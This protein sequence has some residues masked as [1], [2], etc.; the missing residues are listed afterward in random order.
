MISTSF[1]EAADFCRRK[2]EQGKETKQ[3]FTFASMRPPTFAGGNLTTTGGTVLAMPLASMRP[4]TFAGGN[5]AKAGGRDAVRGAS[6]RPPTFAGGNT[7]TTTSA[8]RATL[9]FNEAADFCRR[10]HD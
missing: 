9:S 4:P 7:S 2:L 1:N 10:K 5:P 6:M 3:Q 8:L